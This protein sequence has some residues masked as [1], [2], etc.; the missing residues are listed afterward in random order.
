MLYIKILLTF[1]LGIGFFSGNVFA[2]DKLLSTET[3]IIKY[4]ISGDQKGTMTVYFTDYGKK[5]SRHIEVS[6]NFMG[7]SQKMN[8]IQYLDGEWEYNYDPLT[9]RAVRVNTAEMAY[10]LPDDQKIRHM[11]YFNKIDLAKIA[12]KKGT[13][14]IANKRCTVWEMNDNQTKVC[15]YKDQLPLKSEMNIGGMSM[16]WTAVSYEENV[17]IPEEKLTIPASAKI[18]TTHVSDMGRNL[19]NAQNYP[20]AENL[21]LTKQQNTQSN[22]SLSDM[23]RTINTASKAKR[24]LGKL[25]SLFKK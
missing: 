6:S 24:T 12:K 3:G 21:S 18:Q 16:I 11:N 2:N 15:L 5:Q 10:N 23:D 9:N 13:K 7:E 25:K 22:N 17:D 20:T 14:K 8:T 1:M 4:K 19:G